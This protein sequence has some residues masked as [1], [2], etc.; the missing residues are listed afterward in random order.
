MLYYAQKIQYIYIPSTIKSCI[1]GCFRYVY[2]KY[3]IY[4][5]LFTYNI[6]YKEFVMIC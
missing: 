1:Y 5:Q 4:N 3:L 6:L 2:R